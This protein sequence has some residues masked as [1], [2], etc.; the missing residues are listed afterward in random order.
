MANHLSFSVL[1]PFT[2]TIPSHKP[3]L[4]TNNLTFSVIHI[5][6]LVWRDV[7]QRMIKCLCE[8]LVCVDGLYE[9][10]L[11][12]TL[13]FIPVLFSVLHPFTQTI[14]AHEPDN[15]TNHLPFSALHPFTQTIPSHKPFIMSFHINHLSF[16]VLHPFTQTIA[17]HKPSLHNNHLSFS[18]LYIIWFMWR[19]EIQRVM[20][21][22]CEGLVCVDGLCEPSLYYTQYCIPVMF[23][24]LNPFTQTIPSHKPDNPTNYKS[25]SVLHPFTQTISSHKPFIISLHTNHLSIF[26]LPSFTQTIP[27]HK[28]SLHTNH[29]SFSVLQINLFVWRDVIQRMIN[30][31]CEG[32]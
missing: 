29:L 31:L 24:V 7:I 10:S 21:G 19:D 9:P 1:H 22:L 17:S 27:S 23:S 3:S 25:F 5:I 4:H 16:S 14:P 11:Y 30:G 20:N 6:W 28:P 13:Y 12:Y 32:M 15:H 2:Q 8:G 26:V 18:V